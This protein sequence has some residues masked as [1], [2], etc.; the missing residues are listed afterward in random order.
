[1][2]DKPLDYSLPGLALPVAG[3]K[4][5]RPGIGLRPTPGRL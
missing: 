4:R 5:N 2:S 3:P 1:L